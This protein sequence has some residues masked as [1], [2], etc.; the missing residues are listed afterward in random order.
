MTLAVASLFIDL[1]QAQRDLATQFQDLLGPDGAQAVQSVIAH[2]QDVRVGS[3]ASALGLLILLFGAS[4][5][6]AELQS[7]LNKIPLA[8]KFGIGVGLSLLLLF[9]YWFIFYSDVASKIE[10]ADRVLSPLP[11]V[12]FLKKLRF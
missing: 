2:G 5:V 9:G 1:T 3:V 12:E 7:A 8:G 11:F 10:G 4:Q 6:F